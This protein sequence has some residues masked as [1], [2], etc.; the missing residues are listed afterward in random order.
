MRVYKTKP[1][2][3]FQRRERIVDAALC[4]AVLAAMDGLVDAHLGGGL[5]KQ[6]VARQGGGKRGGYRTVIAFRKGVRAFFL[7]GFAK[8][9][10][11]SID[12]VELV[13]LK[14]RAFG[15]LNASDEALE[16]MIADDELMEVDCGRKT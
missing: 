8:S 14:Q 1:F 2:A 11:A 10:Q 5:I 16:A 4:A 12:D 15:L 3:R 9:E 6:R 13:T 7:L